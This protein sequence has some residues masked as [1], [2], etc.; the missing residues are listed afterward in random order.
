MSDVLAAADAN[1]P[2]FTLKE[3]YKECIRNFLKTVVVI[4]DRAYKSTPVVNA[5]TVEEPVNPFDAL[6]EDLLGDKHTSQIVEPNAE[7]ANDDVFGGG[8]EDKDHELDGPGLVRLFAHQGVICSVIQ[9]ET[10]TGLEPLVAEI[11]SIAQAADV[12]V[13]DWELRPGDHTASLRAVHEIVTHDASRGG[14]LR[15]IVVYTA[16]NQRPVKKAIKDV[17]GNGVVKVV[18]NLMKVEHACIVVLNKVSIAYPDGVPLSLL[19]ER[20]FELHS[21]FSAGVLPAAALSAIGTIRNHTHQVLAQFKEN[22]DAAFITHRAL[23]PKSDDAEAHLI[24]LVA[25]SLH[26]L[27]LTEGVRAQLSDKLCIERL[28]ELKSADVSDEAT[29]VIE[30]CLSTFRTDKLSLISAA[31]KISKEEKHPQKRIM[32]KFYSSPAGA[33]SARKEMAFLHD[34]TRSHLLKL[35]SDYPPRL[36]LGTVVAKALAQSF[37]FYLCIQPRCDSIRFQNIRAF[38]LMKLTV[39]SDAPNIHLEWHGSYRSL[40]VSEK[41]YDMYTFEFGVTG[42]STQAVVGSF[43]H[44]ISKWFFEDGQKGKLYWVGDLRRDKA[45]RLVS[46][47]ASRL[48]LPGINEYEP[49]RVSDDVAR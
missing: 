34:F 12:L 31:L 15:F 44:N 22:L 36:T 42:S 28:R 37:E 47:I 13:L 46:K 6:T 16:A 49:T 9:P 24:E 11:K 7:Q 25:D 27:M 33:E 10:D 4:D 21:E 35:S 8:V 38:P 18:G 2:V 29:A 30:S 1:L 20:I 41:L 43:D 32:E 14:R 5:V 40:S 45:Q 39:T 19:P 3:H 23:I 17:F 48:H 26:N